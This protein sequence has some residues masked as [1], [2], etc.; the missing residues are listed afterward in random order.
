LSWEDRLSETLGFDTS[1]LVLNKKF[2]KNCV[3]RQEKGDA[4]KEKKSRAAGF[5]PDAGD[6]E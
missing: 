5:K 2:N 6:R 4:K 3:G 1:L